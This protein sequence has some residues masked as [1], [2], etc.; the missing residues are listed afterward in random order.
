[1]VCVCLE[2]RFVVFL[3]HSLLQLTLAPATILP[4]FP[5]FFMGFIEIVVAGLPF[6]LWSSPK[7]IRTAHT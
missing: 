3:Q 4:Q 7:R 5:F 1:M 2:D 6:F